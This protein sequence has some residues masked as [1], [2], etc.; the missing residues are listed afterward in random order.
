MR[1]HKLKDSVNG[2]LGKFPLKRYIPKILPTIFCFLIWGLRPQLAVLRL[3]L[4]LHSK[5]TP[6]DDWR[7]TWDA[8]DQNQANSVQ[9][10]HPT[11]SPIY[12]SRPHLISF[13]P[14]ANK[15]EILPSK[16]DRNFCAK[17]KLTEK[18]RN[19]IPSQLEFHYP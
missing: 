19:V 10:K 14:K 11:C 18:C 2:S 12:H 13:K 4:D 6:G 15:S 16:N 8:R 1:K 5:I 3:L 7:T 17:Q 9:G